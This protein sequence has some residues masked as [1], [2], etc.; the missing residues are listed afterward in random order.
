MKSPMKLATFRS[1]ADFRAW[2][3][4]HH[5]TTRELMLRL[6]KT[7]ARER[8]L[9]YRD[10]LDEALCYGWI[11]GVRRAVDE[12]SFSQRFSPRKAKSVWSAVNIKRASE[13][14]A[15][16][17]MQPPG[18][19]AFRARDKIA[20]AP[21]S[22]ENRG[23]RLDAASE[24]TFRAHKRAWAFFQTQ[25]P[26]Y[27]R[28]TAFWVMSAKKEETRAR[29]LGIVI[30]KAERGAAIPPLARPTA[31]AKKKRS[32]ARSRIRSANDRR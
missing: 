20:N 11:D 9:T 18:L 1:V 16:G 10:A 23:V 29:R 12:D 3:E 21:Y 4:E 14:E 27:Q 25:A 8:G 2:L 5:A 31:G 22:F 30:A 32:P 19:A 28:T 13:L 6:Y 15:A 17:R 24:K 7:H 26:W